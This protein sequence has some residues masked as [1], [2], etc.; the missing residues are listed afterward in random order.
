VRLTA[1]LQKRI[2]AFVRIVRDQKLQHVVMPLMAVDHA[3]SVHHIYT[4]EVRL[5]FDSTL[6]VSSTEVWVE[7]LRKAWREE[8]PPEHFATDRLKLQAIMPIDYLPPCEIAL[9]SV[10]SS[11]AARPY[12]EQLRGL[13]E[14]EQVYEMMSHA[15][16]AVER[17]V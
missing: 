10:I 13:L 9:S 14:A 11:A 1:L 4:P 2:A 3:W 15:A 5:F 17:E 7:C 12:R 8:D 16:Y 6:C